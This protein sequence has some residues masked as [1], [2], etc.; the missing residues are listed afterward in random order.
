[1]G[2]R[3]SADRRLTMLRDTST[4]DRLRA[5]DAASEFDGSG[6]DLGQGGELSVPTPRP[7]R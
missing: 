3:L 6:E 5:M 2:S 1:M 7:R 4:D